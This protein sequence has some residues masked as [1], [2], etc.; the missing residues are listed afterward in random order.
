MEFAASFLWFVFLG[1]TM[2]VLSQ[3]GF[4]AYLTVHQFGV[5]IFRTLTLWNWVQ[6]LIIALVIFDL[7]KFR[8][9]PLAETQVTN[10]VV[11][12][13]IDC[14]VGYRIGCC[15]LQ[16]QMDKKTHVHF[17]VIFHDC[18]HNFRMVTCFDGR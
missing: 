10:A 15:L 5:N 17:R 12:R 8:F 7:I 3:M 18:H 6:L 9:M 2:S 4:F 16:S 11:L 14:T 13:T 1:M